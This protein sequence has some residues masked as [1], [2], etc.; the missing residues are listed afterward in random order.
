MKRSNGGVLVEDT[1]HTIT[2]D[3]CTLTK[4]A[5]SEDER[6]HAAYI[7]WPS[8]RCGLITTFITQRDSPCSSPLPSIARAAERTRNHR[9]ACLS[10]DTMS[11]GGRVHI[12]SLRETCI[13]YA[14]ALLEARARA[15]SHSIQHTATACSKGRPTFRAENGGVSGLTRV[16]FE[17]GSENLHYI[18]HV[19]HLR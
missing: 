16:G 8:E 17:W 10:L 2:H 15:P 1:L 13:M 11:C 6:R 4:A 12:M 9:H 3:H 14:H 7:P 19:S 18:H 5:M